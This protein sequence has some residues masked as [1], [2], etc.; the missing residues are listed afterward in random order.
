MKVKLNYQYFNIYLCC[1][2]AKKFEIKTKRLVFIV[3]K[4]IVPVWFNYSI[5]KLTGKMSGIINIQNEEWILIRINKLKSTEISLEYDLNRDIFNKEEY[6]SLYYFCKNNKQG[7]VLVRT[8][9]IKQ[10]EVNSLNN[11]SILSKTKYLGNINIIQNWDNTDTN[12]LT[13]D[14]KYIPRYMNVKFINYNKLENSIFDYINS[15]FWKTVIEFKNISFNFKETKLVIEG[16]ADEF[17]TE[18]I[19]KNVFRV[20]V[21]SK[22]E[23]FSYRDLWN[24]LIAKAI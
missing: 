8:Q 11:L 20:R 12:K 10:V 24:L 3:H 7:W 14:I 15:E 5:I 2:P 18:D 9:D 16:I 22:S 23:I 13:N 17:N 19:S 1:D 21:D 6:K 4:S